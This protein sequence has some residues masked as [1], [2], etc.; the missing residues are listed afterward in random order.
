MKI[1]HIA[2][3]NTAGVPLTLVKAER[4]NGHYSRLITFYPSPTMQGDDIVLN[5]PLVN[6]HFLKMGKSMLH[7]G[8]YKHTYKTGNPPLWT[9]DMF[10]KVFF[11]FRDKI[12]EHRIKPLINFIQGFDVYILDGG[13]GLL[14]SGK[15][16]EKLKEQGKKIIII[17]FGSDLRSRGAIKRIE[18]L[19]DKIFTV[20]FDHIF[21]HPDAQYLFFPF[22]VG[23]YEPKELRKGKNITICHCPTN[24]YLKGTEF[25]IE[26]IGKLKRK[27]PIR[28]L[29]MEHIP[30]EDVIKLKQKECDVLI[31]QLT[32]LGGYGYGINSL[33]ALSMGIPCITYINPEYEKFIPDHPFINANVKNIQEVIEGVILNEK[34]REEK[35]IY[36]R[37]WVKKYHSA[38]NISNKILNSFESTK[39]IKRNP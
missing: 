14:R 31:D 9:P 20:E 22:E 16:V 35:G 18:D 34:L 27:Y 24:R 2:S 17:Y 32:D 7:L 25:V 15:I 23:R 5:L 8:T 12:W 13:M 33:E 4:R 26:A 28:F 21:I 30:H 3:E 6:T 1:L 37:K 19:A 39:T 29:L 38:D 36:G 11:L 10:E